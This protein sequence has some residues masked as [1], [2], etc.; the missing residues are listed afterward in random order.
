MKD[1]VK[2]VIALVKRMSESGWEEA[3]A[4]TAFLAQLREKSYLV[5]EVGVMQAMNKQG[6]VDVIKGLLKSVTLQEEAKKA[7]VACLQGLAED[8]V[9]NVKELA[10]GVMAEW[11]SKEP[12]IL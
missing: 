10:E 8:Q 9:V 2:C 6:V 12:D 11:R 7:L 4:E 5:R 3:V 1:R